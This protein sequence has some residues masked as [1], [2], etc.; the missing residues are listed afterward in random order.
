MVLKAVVSRKLRWKSD[1][2]KVYCTVTLTFDICISR[3]NP[4]AE[5]CTEPCYTELLRLLKQ[6]T[7]EKV[8][9]TSCTMYQHQYSWE[10]KSMIYHLE[11]HL[12]MNCTHLYIIRSLLVM[13]AMQE[14]SY[15]FERKGLLATENPYQKFHQTQM[16]V[17]FV[18]STFH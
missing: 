13:Q 16:K 15:K 3:K 18:W 9:P 6:M 8:T 5:C 10:S 7:G 1:N 11:E 2:E 14:I 4:D 12:F 17:N